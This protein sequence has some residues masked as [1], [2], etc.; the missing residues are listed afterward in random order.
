V[1]PGTRPDD[2]DRRKSLPLQGLQIR[3]LGRPAR[4]QLLYR[5]SY[6]GSGDLIIGS[7][8]FVRHLSFARYPVIY[9]MKRV[10]SESNAKQ[11]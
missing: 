1:G 6:P 2:V 8:L 11:E 5:L 4:T 10:P 9:V 7:K 3:P